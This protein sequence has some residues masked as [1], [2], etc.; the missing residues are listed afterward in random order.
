[1]GNIIRHTLRLPI[2]H[3]HQDRP[4]LSPFSPVD[5]T[6][7]QQHA[8]HSVLH[9]HV[10]H[11]PRS[12]VYFHRISGSCIASVFASISEHTSA[13][14]YRASSPKI[15]SNMEGKGDDTTKAQSSTYLPIVV[16]WLVGWILCHICR[17]TRSQCNPLGGLWRRSTS[18]IC[19]HEEKE[20]AIYFYFLQK[21]P[22]PS[23]LHPNRL[24]ACLKARG[25]THKSHLGLP[26][27]SLTIRDTLAFL[28]LA[29]F[30]F[31]KPN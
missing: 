18:D 24:L 11:V 3:G 31:P 17:L 20:S 10:S 22:V 21:L 26:S 30:P 29:V 28:P 14:S 19:K 13:V 7:H 27:L 6:S 1:M 2:N 8:Y 23:A 12:R 5:Q 16:I 15:E 4:H 9:R 25:F